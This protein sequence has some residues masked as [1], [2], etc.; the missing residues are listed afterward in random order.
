MDVQK[1][2]KKEFEDAK[3][4]MLEQLARDKEERFGKSGGASVTVGG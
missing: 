2:E 3:R 4:K 1:R